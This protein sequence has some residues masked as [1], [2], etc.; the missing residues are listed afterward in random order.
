MSEKSW[1]NKGVKSSSI[2]PLKQTAKKLLAV[3]I[4]MVCTA[5]NVQYVPAHLAVAATLTPAISQAGSANGISG[6]PAAD[7][8]Q[9]VSVAAPHVI[10]SASIQ[11][12]AQP[13]NVDAITLQSVSQ[14]AGEISVLNTSPE[15]IP[16][17]LTVQPLAPLF[18]LTTPQATQYVE[19]AIGA[20]G[21]PTR[22]SAL[23][24]NPET[25]FVGI[26]DEAFAF[27]L[28]IA[29]VVGI[30]QAAKGFAVPDM[31]TVLRC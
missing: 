1:Y 20:A 16:V 9:V 4:V 2:T 22:D 7:T 10:A 14:I 15:N 19:S 27:L 24:P 25:S 29:F 31:T 3:G 5:L 11:V 21:I 28:L 13:E 12:T 6:Q 8:L 30:A 26:A 17:A 23:P 18:S